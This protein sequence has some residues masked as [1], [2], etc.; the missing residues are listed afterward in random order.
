MVLNYITNL[1][2]SIQYGMPISVDTQYSR[3]ALE[4]LAMTEHCSELVLVKSPGRYKR[5]EIG[6]GGM[7][8]P[9]C[10]ACVGV[11]GQL[12]GVREMTQRVMVPPRLKT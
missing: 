1:Q 4:T 2:S 3:I 11:R 9:P 12:S 8:E 6:K 5:N 7:C 10:G